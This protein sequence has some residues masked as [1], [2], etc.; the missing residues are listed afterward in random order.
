ML[1]TEED[2]PRF[3]DPLTHYIRDLLDIVIP[4]RIR[5]ETFLQFSKRRA[6]WMTSGSSAGEFVMIDGKRCPVNKR[7]V[8]ERPWM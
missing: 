2:H 8:G 4:T 6:E 7:A 1:H 3:Y 5:R